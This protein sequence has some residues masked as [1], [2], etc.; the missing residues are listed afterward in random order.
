MFV[1]E[2][3]TFACFVEVDTQLLTLK[4]IEARIFRR[5]V[6]HIAGLHRDSKEVSGSCLTGNFLSK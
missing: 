4:D 5:K 6:N 2:I 1:E 3:T